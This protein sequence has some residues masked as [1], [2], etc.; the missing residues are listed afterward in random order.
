MYTCI[1]SLLHL[2][3]TRLYFYSCSLVYQKY[4]DMLAF[5]TIHGFLQKEQYMKLYPFKFLQIFLH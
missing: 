2:F 3:P 1:P 5:H 4:L